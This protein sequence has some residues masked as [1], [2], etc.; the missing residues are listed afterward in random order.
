VSSAGWV[1]FVVLCT[2]SSVT[3]T[4]SEGLPVFAVEHLVCNV[5]ECEI[6]EPHLTALVAF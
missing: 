3:Y 4:Y 1:K 2:V 5:W 6:V